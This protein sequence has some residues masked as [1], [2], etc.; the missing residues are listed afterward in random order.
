MSFA[1]DVKKELTKIMGDKCCQ[2]AELSALLRSNGEIFIASNGLTIDYLTQNPTIAKR[3]VKLLKSVYNSEIELITKK[4][5]RL[6]R[7]NT[8]VVRINDDVK[9]IIKDLEL[10]DGLTPMNN[11]PLH[12]TERECCKRAY[13]RGVFISC[14]SVN[15]PRTSHYHLELLIKDENHGNDVLSLINTFHYNAKMIIRNKGWMIYMKEADKISD[16]LKLIEAYGSVMFYEDI[17]IYRDINNSINRMNN[18]DIANEKKVL[19]TARK[20]IEDIDYIENSIGLENLNE[21][22]REAA[23]LRKENPEASLNELLEISEEI[24]GKELSKSGLNHRFRKI[25]A[26]AEDIM[27]R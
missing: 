15:N 10:M 9:S 19:E 23:I 25:K 21:K 26:I 20:Q 17:R 24:I 6:N 11:I 2:V 1:A 27:G 4:Q 14:G 8:Y 5:N 7:R 13:L 16:F 18:C 12:L 22:L 3:V